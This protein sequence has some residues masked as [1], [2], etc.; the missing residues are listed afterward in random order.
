MNFPTLYHKGKSGELR[1]WRVWSK[2]DQIFTEYGIVG[3]KLQV[4]Q[5]TAVPKNVGRSNETTGEEQAASEAESLHKFKLERKYSETPEGAQEQLPLPMTAHS[6]SNTSGKITTKGKKFEWPGYLQPKLDGVRC[7]AEN[8]GGEIRLTSRQGKPYFVPVIQEQ[9]AKWLPEGTILDGEIYIHGQSCQRVTSWVKSANPESKSYKPESLNL[10][11]HVYDVPTHRGDDSL[12]WRD[13]LANLIAV[14][15]RSDNITKVY[16]EYVNS[17]A[18][19][20][21]VYGQHMTDGY[22]G[23]MLRGN[24]GTYLWGYRSAHLLKVKKFQDAE[25][26]V[27]AARGGRG[28]M[29]GCVVWVCRND[30]TDGTFEC[31]MKATMEERRQFYLDRDEYIGKPLT[32]RFFDRTDDQIPRFPVGVVFRDTKDLP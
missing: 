30:V 26:T 16:G 19:M 25:F 4:S 29:E 14:V 8:V 28:K 3:G 9:L 7:L 18:D 24:S 1:Q 5:K 6:Y 27:V 23:S 21:D 20:W 17:E 22:E 13:R 15:K 32:I 31:S 2:G 12:P 11:Y 10:V